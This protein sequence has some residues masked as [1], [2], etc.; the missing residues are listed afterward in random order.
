[1]L[2]ADFLA[3][4]PFLQVEAESALRDRARVERRAQGAT[5]DPV[6]GAR[7]DV[8][9]TVAAVV[10]CRVRVALGE[11]TGTAGV[12]SMTVQRMTCAVPVSVADVRV[13]DR[14]VVLSSDDLS[15]V[16]V[17]LYVRAVPRGTGMAL[18]RLTV[19]DRQ[20]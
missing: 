17:A 4:L 11:L 12:E 1:M 6:T 5:I 18:R 3:A 7:V 8:W 15:L 19:A 14:L 16:G 10:P 20:E 9:S 2:G 13:G